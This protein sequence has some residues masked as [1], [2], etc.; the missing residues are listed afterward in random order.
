MPYIMVHFWHDVNTSPRKFLK[1]VQMNMVV[2]FEI[3][4]ILIFGSKYGLGT[5]KNYFI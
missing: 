3:F 1:K 5:Q 2:N 4:I